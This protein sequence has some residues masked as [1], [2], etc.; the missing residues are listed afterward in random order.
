MHVP[1][2]NPRLHMTGERCRLQIQAVSSYDHFPSTSPSTHWDHMR[3]PLFRSARVAMLAVAVVI[4]TGV[5]GVGIAATEAQGHG[6]DRSA[7]ADTDTRTYSVPLAR[8]TFVADR[9]AKASTSD[10]GILVNRLPQ[11]VGGDPDGVIRGV[12]PAAPGRA[13]AH[14]STVIETDALETDEFDVVGVTWESG[15]ARGEV[16]AWIRTRV[17]GEWSGWTELHSDAD[18]PDRDSAEGAD[19]RSGTEPLAALGSDAIQISIVTP[20]GS[21]PD[22]VQ[23]ELVDP[24]A[25]RGPA[26]ENSATPAEPL[27]QS[28]LASAVARPTIYSRSDWGADESIREPGPPEYG[29]VMGGFVHHTAGANDYASAEVPTIIQGIY[30]YHVNGRGWRDIGY[31]FLVDR[32][33]RIWEGRYGGIDRAVVG[34]QVSGYNSSSTGVSVLGDFTDIEP[35][36]ATTT[37]IEELL[38]WKFSIHDVDPEGTVSYPAQATLPKISGHRDAGATLCPGELLYA[39][40]D[41][42]RDGVTSRMGTTVDRIAGDNRY[43][44]AGA[45]A[46]QYSTGLDEVYVA[47][48]VDFPDAL[49]AAGAAG[50]ADV[51][52]LLTRPNA[53]PAATRAELQRISP[54]RIV[55][56]GGPLVVSDGVKQDLRQFT[57]TGSADSVVR[58]SG[59]NRSSTSVEVSLTTYPTGTPVPAV[60]VATGQNFPDALGGSAIAGHVGG[61]VLIIRRPDDVPAE[62]LSELSRLAPDQVI[63][64]GGPSIVTDGALSQIEAAVPSAEVARVAGVNRY[65]TAAAASAATYSGGADR[66]FLGTGLNFP[67]ALSAAALAGSVGAPLLLSKTSCLPEQTATELERLGADRVTL[68][69]GPTVLDAEVESLTRC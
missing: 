50:A 60:Y 11:G 43:A 16:S 58:L 37:A 7:G 21:V 52:V 33:G 49:A 41:F 68:V 63:I 10:A 65:G 42:I 67:D 53:I 32:F 39:E 38:A 28:T 20:D 45:V 30:A 24:G 54:T 18:G 8:T 15:S 1:G 19:Q 34:A 44:T 2:M 5:P 55:I 26:V 6:S 4:A 64:L 40:L 48:G 51:P 66:V 36:E 27:T 17:S 56:V 23:L 9:L 3:Q 59:A 61:P 62:V 13:P 31:N 29:S 35:A 46:A 47:T 14:H 69:G 12:L 25:A 57:T 22:G